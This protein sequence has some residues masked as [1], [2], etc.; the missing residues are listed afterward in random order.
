VLPYVLQGHDSHALPKAVKKKAAIQR[1]GDTS[2]S[3]TLDII[4]PEKRGESEIIMKNDNNIRANASVPQDSGKSKQNFELLKRAYETAVASGKDT[5]AELL[6]LSTAVAYSVLNKCIDP[7]RKTAT[8]RDKVSDNGHNPALRELKRGIAA[9]IALLDNLRKAADKATMVVLNK[10]GDMVTEVQDKDAYNTVSSLVGET[11]S[12]GMDLVQTAAE[13]IL[14]ETAEHAGG[15]CWL[16]KP[17]VYRHIKNKVRI[18]L[19]DTA[20]YVDEEVTPIRQ[21]YRAVR[22]YIMKSRAA[23]TD[24]RSK[25]TYVPLDSIG[26]EEGLDD[27]YL[28][29]GKYSDIGGYD[30]MGNYTT[31]LEAVKRYY[32]IL[33]R[34]DLL[35]RQ[36][37]IIDFRLNGAG[38]KAIASYFGISYQAIRNILK[39][40]QAKAEKIGFTPDM[41]SEMMGD[42]E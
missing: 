32:S 17:Y 35:P 40:I 12:D 30:C 5:S 25:Y 1:A 31:G 38:C 18:K 16:D 36:K 11:L 37:Q 26:G 13:A 39:R 28:R 19:E 3:L 22:R 33:D 7:Q 29:M 14:S 4:R 27:V 23:Q 6:A 8:E 20:A 21:V 41:W 15:E 10:D 42:D 9:D 24:P 2:N 34:L